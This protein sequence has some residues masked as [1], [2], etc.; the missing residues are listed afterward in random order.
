MPRSRI[1]LPTH[2]TSLLWN[3]FDA[4]SNA[5]TSRF[6]RGSPPGEENLTFLLCELLD[7]SA[8]DLHRL[9]YS[10]SDLKKALESGDSGLTLDVRFDT[11]PHSKH[12]ESKYS[13]ADLGLVLS[14]DH[15]MLGRSTRAVLLQAKK[16]FPARRAEQFSLYS[17]YSSFDAAQAKFLESLAR[18]FDAWRSV[19]YLWY[20]PS[21]GAFDDTA[22]KHIRSYEATSTALVPWRRHPFMD[23]LIEFGYPFAFSNHARG[24]TSSERD[25]ELQREW[26]ASQPAMRVSSL[27]VAMS[28]STGPSAPSIRALYDQIAEQSDPVAFSP[29]ADFMLLALLNPRFGSSQSEWIALAEGRLTKLPPKKQQQAN[30]SNVDP[31]DSVDR[32]PVP[33]HTLRVSLRSTLPNQG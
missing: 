2:E 17:T 30:D 26:R 6:E 4:V 22:S 25:A 33:R 9:S 3:Y 10:L 31:T 11:H 7:E 28:T 23:E 20:N 16:L 18:R 1:M 12:F 24:S 5:I 13:G 15:P 29:F 14:I 21:T 8:S 27:S 19:F 32:P